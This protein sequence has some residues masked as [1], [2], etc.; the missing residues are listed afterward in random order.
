MDPVFNPGISPAVLPSFIIYSYPTV[1]L[2]APGPN[3]IGSSPTW[4]HT[5]WLG[6]R[7][8]IDGQPYVSKSFTVNIAHECT[9]ASI[10]SAVPSFPVDYTELTTSSTLSF[11]VFTTTEVVGTTCIMYL[12]QILSAGTYITADTTNTKIISTFGYPDL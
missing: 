6:G 1:T 4:S 12:W 7:V 8:K 9:R 10:N 2:T 5:Y 11:N 3:V